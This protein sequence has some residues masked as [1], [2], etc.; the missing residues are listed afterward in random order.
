MLTERKYPLAEELN[1]ESSARIDELVSH[2]QNEL[3]S[4]ISGE[5]QE[6]TLFEGDFVLAKNKNQLYQI[7]V[8]DGLSADPSELFIRFMREIG[9]KGRIVLTS[10]KKEN[11]FIDGQTPAALHFRSEFP[12]T[13]FPVIRKDY[14]LKIEPG[15]NLLVYCQKFYFADNEDPEKATPLT[16]RW[17]AENSNQIDLEDSPTK[18]KLPVLA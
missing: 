9:K 16:W 14:L 15:S 17:V 4:V 18:E 1:F 7:G 11:P 13:P 10:Q 2:F 6:A 12:Y 8:G 5:T 3:D